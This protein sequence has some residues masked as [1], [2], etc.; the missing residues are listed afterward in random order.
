MLSKEVKA[1]LEQDEN[2]PFASY[3]I[4][5]GED[6]FERGQREL[7]I[8]IASVWCILHEAGEDGY[9]LPDKLLP[10]LTK[11]L[12]TPLKDEEETAFRIWL[13][14][15]SN[16]AKYNFAHIDE[17]HFTRALYGIYRVLLPQERGI[18]PFDEQILDSIIQA[19]QID[20]AVTNEFGVAVKSNGLDS[21]VI[22]VPKGAESWTEFGDQYLIFLL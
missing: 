4:R 9:N 13:Q 1:W 2:L 16:A 10:Y 14:M 19:K 18:E 6:K 12:E 3:F 11:L 5:L 15:C 20:F 22:I 7:A 21:K 8:E 17:F